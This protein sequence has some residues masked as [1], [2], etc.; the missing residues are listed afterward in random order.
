[1]LLVALAASDSS[2]FTKRKA[3]WH[4]SLSRTGDA[5]SSEHNEPLAESQNWGLALVGTVVATEEKVQRLPF[6][7]IF[8]DES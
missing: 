8:V 4:S 6:I 7:F 3:S 5:S 2:S 1:M